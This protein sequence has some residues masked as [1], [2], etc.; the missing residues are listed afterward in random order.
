MRVICVFFL[1][2]KTCTAA[3]SASS[4]RLHLQIQVWPPLGQGSLVAMSGMCHN[5]Q[6]KFRCLMLINA[7][8]TAVSLV[9]LLWIYRP[10]RTLLIWADPPTSQPQPQIRMP[11]T[12]SPHC[13][14]GRIVPLNQK[15][16]V[17]RTKTLLISAY[18]EHR[19][20]TREVRI[21]AV[22]QRSEKATYRCFLCCQHQLHVSDAVTS[23]HADHFN[24][25]YGTADIMC[26]IPPHCLSPSHVAVTSAAGSATGRPGRKF[27]MVKNRAAKS[28]TF[29]F[30]FTVCL[31][32]MFEFTNVLQLVQSLEMLQLLGVNRV[33]VYETSSS[34]QT[35]R[36]L[37]YYTHKGLLEVI[38]WS[39]TR[40]LNVSRGWVPK[41]DAGDLHYFGQVPALNDCLYRY[42]Y[43]TQYLALHD[44]DELILPQSVSSWLELL[45][46]LERIYGVDRCYM[47]ENNVFPTTVHRPPPAS[48]VVPPQSRCCPSWKLVPGV[49]ILSHLYHEPVV[50]DT[51][52]WNFKIIVNP[53]AVF[54][55]TVHGLLSSQNGCSWVDRNIARMYHTRAPVQTELSPENLIYDGRLLS[56]SVQFTSTVNTVL[57][58]CG[59]LPDDS[60]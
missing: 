10:D 20:D 16:Q 51:H 30:H 2:C 19:M 38:P 6:K 54:S 23:V 50:S 37:D 4:E 44:V 33:V 60:I 46:L 52:Y 17:D 15:V 13:G 25:A 1:S 24:F 12:V 9:L 8:V 53:R 22:V 7:V 57:T 43:R 32:T 34:A 42:M 29:P 11:P 3:V 26:P 28:H 56:Y 18:Q 49:N 31:S 48:V 59:L 27:L 47:F 36:I 41:D 14:R 35:Q 39:L 55:P 5:N 58:E 40:F 21:I 45:P